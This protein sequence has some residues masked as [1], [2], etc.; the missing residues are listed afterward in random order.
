[1]SD[2]HSTEEQPN[3]EQFSNEIATEDFYVTVEEAE[4]NEFEVSPKPSF[5]DEAQ[6]QVTPKVVVC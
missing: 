6:Q 5:P 4:T 3:K 2:S 1:M